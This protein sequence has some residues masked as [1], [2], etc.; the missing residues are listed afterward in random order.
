MKSF[1]SILSLTLCIS[2]IAQNRFSQDTVLRNIYDFQYNRNGSALSTY[3][4]YEDASYR[5]AAVISFASV[6]NKEFAGLLS[7]L[8]KKDREVSVR[9]AAAYS[10]GQ[11][12]DST[13]CTELIA[14]YKLE[15]NHLVKAN[16]LEAIGKSADMN[17]AVFL[18]AIE[19]KELDSVLISAYVKA[20]YHTYRRKRLNDAI[21]KN[22]KSISS[23]KSTDEVK[24]LCQKVLNPLKPKDSKKSNKV[25]TLKQ[26]NDSL[27]K[28]VNP[29]YKTQ[30]LM[31]KN[32]SSNDWYQLAG[33]AE[34]NV[35][36]TYC[37]EQY[38]K[39]QKQVPDSILKKFL[40]SG[41][42]ASVSLACERIRA[43][44]LWDKDAGTYYEVLNNAM[45]TL[46]IP[47]DYEA[48][49]DIYKTQ[50]Q[51]NKVQFVY[52]NF[53]ESGYQ[54][55]VDWNYVTNIEQNKKVR[56][57][58]SK[59]DIV[60]QCKVN[61]SPAS[62]ANFLKLVDSGFY[63]GKYFHRFVEDFVIQGGCPRGD[64]WGSLNWMQRSEFGSELRYKPGS[65]GLASAGK[66]SEGV[67]FFITHT[68]TTNLDGRY[69]IFAEVTEGMDV[70]NSLRVGDMIV[71]IEVMEY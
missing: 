34:S 69:T 18:G 68:Y 71:S 43:D 13:N 25:F 28:Y 35:M 41:D 16:I 51:I 70:V 2:A 26:V 15:Q 6:Q 42:V 60:I 63:N 66:D 45:A 38:F 44:S 57:K 48:W 40:F 52:P 10:I 27:A 59:G 53:F 8:L 31:S 23:G 46:V 9:A 61:E 55:P 50:Q 19:M 33:N 32:L 7:Y 14:S 49:L 20:A 17:S 22:L 5:Y 62:V 12:Y 54:N 3:L 4:K 21:R 39:E 65:V 11:L 58:T 30:C 64:G 29:Y 37:I 47:R 36:R 24:V 1:F 67:Q 56:I